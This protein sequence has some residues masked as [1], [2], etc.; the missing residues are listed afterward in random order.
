M[1]LQSVNRKGKAKQ[2]Y[3][4]NEESL[5]KQTKRCYRNH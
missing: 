2:Y 1:Q 5:Q 4:N 3:E